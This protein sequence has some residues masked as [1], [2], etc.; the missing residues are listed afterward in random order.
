MAIAA[1]VSLAHFTGKHIPL[2]ENAH[3]SRR[4]YQFMNEIAV[5]REKEGTPLRDIGTCTGRVQIGHC[6]YAG[7]TS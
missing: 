6:T 1:F 4:M 3:Q 2:R 5:A 7:E